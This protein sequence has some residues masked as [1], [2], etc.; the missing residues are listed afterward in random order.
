MKA[1]R[2][3]MREARQLFRSCLVNDRLDEDRVRNVIRQ[4]LDGKTRG[5]LAVASEL[6]RW[7]KRYSEQHT[8]RIESAV[9]LPE[10]LQARMSGS[11]QEEYGSGIDVQYIHRPEL[12]GGVRVIVGS[13]V[14]DGSV[15][16]E[17]SVLEK[18]FGAD[19]GR[20]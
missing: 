3:M 6:Q 10:D 19:Q 11:L 2:Q 15:Q 7:V 4:V 5:Y 9:P 12:I 16:Y 8:A 1:S 20:A 17:L 18:S 13:D 14:H